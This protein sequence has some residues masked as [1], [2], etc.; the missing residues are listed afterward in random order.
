MSCALGTPRGGGG[1]PADGRGEAFVAPTTR[2]DA[3]SPLPPRPAP[4]ADRHSPPGSAYPAPAAASRNPAWSPPPPACAWGRSA[5]GWCPATPA[6]APAPPPRRCRPGTRARRRRAARCRRRCCRCCRPGG[7]SAGV[8]ASYCWAVRPRHCCRCCCCYCC[9]CC[10]CTAAPAAAAPAGALQPSVHARSLAG[11]RGEGCCCALPVCCLGLLLLGKV[12][13]TRGC[14]A[15]WFGQK[16]HTCD[17]D[18]LAAR[19]GVVGQCGALLWPHCSLATT[20][21]TH[22]V[23]RRGLLQAS[24]RSPVHMI[25]RARTAAARAGALGLPGSPTL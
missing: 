25:K 8:G 24:S 20:P 3:P 18:K 23:Q 19:P 15:L 7:G 6:P 10:S 22:A 14:G 5:T 13:R 1:L 16:C 4:P 9:W 2:V 21:S 11:P 12:A 17:E